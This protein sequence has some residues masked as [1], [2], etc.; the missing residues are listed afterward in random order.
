VDILGYSC[1]KSVGPRSLG[2][3]TTG[4]GRGGDTLYNYR[5]TPIP[6]SAASN[7]ETQE[8]P[9]CNSSPKTSRL[10]TKEAEVFWFKFK[11]REKKKVDAQLKGQRNFV[12]AREGRF[13]LYS[14]LQSIGRG[15]HTLGKAIYFT[16]SINL[17]VKLIQKHAHRNTQNKV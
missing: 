8:R 11:G 12:L 9:W 15:L 2:L 14:V 6:E 1:V 17:N 10:D 3:T 4:R 16:Q 7:M 5:G 13:L